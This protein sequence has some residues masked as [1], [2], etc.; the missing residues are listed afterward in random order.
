MRIIKSF[1]LMFM[2]VALNLV[3]LLSFGLLTWAQDYPNKPTSLYC[4][5]AAGATTDLTA[6]ALA[7]G[8]G[9][10]FGCPNHGG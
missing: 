8:G 10:D 7:T 5:Y 2:A 9:E 1:S 3:F 6:R 4:G